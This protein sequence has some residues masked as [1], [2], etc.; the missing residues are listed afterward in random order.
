MSGLTKLGGSPLGGVAVLAGASAVV[1]AGTTMLALRDKSYQTDQERI[2]HR[3]GRVA[4]VGGAAVG[5]YAAV[6]SVGALGVAGYGA[7][8]LSS[9]LAALGSVAGG[10]M[11]AGVA[12]VAAIPLLA[13]FALALVAYGLMRSL[14]PAPSELR[15]GT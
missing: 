10:G 12:V 3:V 14:K 2:A 1:G 11:V 4:G 9:G 15:A 5:A 13:A 6:H 8:G 7:A